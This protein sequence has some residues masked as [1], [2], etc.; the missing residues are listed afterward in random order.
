M[1]MSFDLVLIGG[2][3]DLSWRK[4]MPSLCVAR[5]GFTWAEER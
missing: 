1:T 5:D 3:G 4:R 2:T